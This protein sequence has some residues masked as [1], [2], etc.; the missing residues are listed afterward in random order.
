MLPPRSPITAQHSTR[1]NSG[2]SGTVYDAV[3]DTVTARGSGPSQSAPGSGSG[4]SQSAPGFGPLQSASAGGTPSQPSRL[5][6]ATQASGG[7]DPYSHLTPLQRAELN[8]ALHEVVVKYAP[9]FREAEQIKDPNERKVR[10]TGTQNIL[11]AKQS[12][13]RKRFGVRLRHKRTKE[14]IEQERVRMWTLEH[15]APTPSYGSGSGPS[16][17]APGS[18][19]SQSE[20]AGGSGSGPS[21]S[22]PGSGPSQSARHI[23]ERDT[24]YR[25]LDPHAR[26]RVQSRPRQYVDLDSSDSYGE[27]EHSREHGGRRHKIP[28]SGAAASGSTQYR[29]IAPLA[30]LKVNPEGLAY[31]STALDF[32]CFC[33]NRLSRVDLK[34]YAPMYAH[35]YG[36]YG[37]GLICCRDCREV[38]Q[39]RLREA[40]ISNTRGADGKR[41]P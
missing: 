35:I 40:R 16:R 15:G 6:T 12:T 7:N 10:L 34:T 41:G 29:K 39:R 22:A 26:Q 14:E 32:D 20:P 18:E 5:P 33:G 4:P 13:I 36:S 28:A 17:S 37:K 31:V 25:E 1:T 8:E 38:Y 24:G 27:E 21:Q 19:P 23:L 2:G 11:Y 30:S 3:R 9:R